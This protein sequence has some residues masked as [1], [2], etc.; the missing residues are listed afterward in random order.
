MDIEV[1]ENGTLDLSMKKPIKREGSLSGTS[2]EVRS[3]DPSS[4]SSSSSS[5]H[6]S[7]NSGMTS[8]NLHTYK[9]EDWDGPLDFTKPNRQREEEADEVSAPR[10][11][12]VRTRRISCNISRRGS[13]ATKI[14]TDKTPPEALWMK[15]SCLHHFFLSNCL[16]LFPVPFSSFYYSFIWVKNKSYS[17]V[18]TVHC[19]TEVVCQ[20]HCT[21][22]DLAY[23]NFPCFEHFQKKFK[24]P[25]MLIFHDDIS[26][27]ETS[28]EY[29]K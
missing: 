1:D 21:I 14:T 5:L 17:A 12:R 2:P 27:L 29:K 19:V 25:W 3:P 4:S 23:A 9:Q 20:V 8:P 15:S 6:H 16:S 11:N 28:H 13:I 24:G 7:G 18:K 22:R 26:H 10:R